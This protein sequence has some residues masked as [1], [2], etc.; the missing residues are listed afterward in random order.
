MHRVLHSHHFSSWDTLAVLND[1]KLAPNCQSSLCF[2]LG[3]IPD[4]FSV[5]LC[6]CLFCNC[7]KV[8]RNK[9][10]VSILMNKYG[11]LY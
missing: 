4:V 10:N 3:F 11:I 1:S 9:N 7:L 2:T 6:F 8:L 5:C